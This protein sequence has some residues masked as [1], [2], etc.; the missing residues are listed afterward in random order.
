MLSKVHSAVECNTQKLQNL[1]EQVTVLNQTVTK[2]IEE[3]FDK[4][5]ESVSSSLSDSFATTST[6]FKQDVTDSMIKSLKEV[7]TNDVPKRN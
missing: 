7:C 1:E 4:A 2:S 6:D 3:G 5:I